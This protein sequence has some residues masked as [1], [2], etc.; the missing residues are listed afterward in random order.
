MELATGATVS[1]AS[2][3]EFKK[4]QLPLKMQP[5]E[6]S[7]NTFTNEVVKP[8][9]VVKARMFYEDQVNILCLYIL[10][11]DGTVLLGHEWLAHLC[12]D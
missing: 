9:S 12:L 7:L 11:Q 1:V 5:T 3:E 2:K 6:L 10:V 4:L 8:S